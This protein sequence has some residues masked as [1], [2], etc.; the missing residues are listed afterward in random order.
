MQSGLGL[1]RLY[2]DEGD[3][4]AFEALVNRYAAMIYRVSLRLAGDAEEA[5]DC[6]QPSSSSWFG[7]PSDSR[8]KVMAT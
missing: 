5:D 3:E 7:V 6:V 4:Q 1:I 2:C 8:R